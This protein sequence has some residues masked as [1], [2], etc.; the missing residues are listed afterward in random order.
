MKA[1]LFLFIPLLGLTISCQQEKE[2][3]DPEILKQV[4]YEYFDGIK[5]NDLGKMNEA[6]TS[7]FVLYEDGKIWNNDSLSTFLSTL[8]KYTAIFKFDNFNIDVD[9]KSGSMYYSNHGILTFNDTTEVAYE[10]IES[11]SFKKVDGNWKINF[12]HSTVKK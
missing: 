12:A 4:L 5:N 7:D 1:K 3:D 8:P 2:I 6:T 10:W 11:A 9:S